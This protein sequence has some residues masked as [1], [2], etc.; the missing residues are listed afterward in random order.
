MWFSH[1]SRVARIVADIASPAGSPSR[2]KISNVI[3]TERSIAD[4]SDEV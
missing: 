4:E 2:K 3:S 1:R